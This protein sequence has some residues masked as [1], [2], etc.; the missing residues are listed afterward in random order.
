MI[1]LTQGD[2]LKA[3]AEALVNT[4]NC[5]GIMGRGIAL[6]FRK[7]FPE[8]FKAYEF[9]C[10]ADRVQPGKMFVYD[11][12]RLY[13]PRFIINFPTKRHWKNKSRIEDIKAGLADLINVVGQQQIRSIAIPPLGCGLGGLNWEEVRPLI[14]EAFQSVPEVDVLLFEPVGSPQATAMVREKK[15]P[16]MTVGRAALLGLMRRYLAAVMDPTVTL[17]EVHKLMYFMQEAGEPLRLNYQKAPY[18]PYAENL[19]HVIDRIEGHFISGYA[20]A[21]DRPDKPLELNLSASDRAEIFLTGHYATRQ[22]FDRVAELIKGFETTFGMELLSTVH[23][24][25]T[26]EEA[27]TPEEAVT[28]IYDWNTRKRMFESRHIHLA[29]ERLRE[30]GWLAH[31]K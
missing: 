7:A 22:R 14:I 17:L 8:N 10:K 28:K 2:I 9:A 31:I 21:E 6:Q 30:T 11:L 13:N 29:W 5:V 24:V 3:D 25:A 15:V 1:E 26:R 16:N 4:V 19:R 18:G 23:W 20:D 27:A 12:N